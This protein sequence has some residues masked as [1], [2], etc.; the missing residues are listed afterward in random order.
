MKSKIGLTIAALAVAAGALADSAFLVLPANA[1]HI[2]LGF[3]LMR[4]LPPGRIEMACYSGTDEVE[5][6]EIFDRA[7]FRWLTVPQSYWN[8]GSIHGASQDVLIVVGESAA[9]EDLV[10]AAAWANNIFTPSDRNFH[11]TINAIH[12][13]S[14]LSRKQWKTLGKN[15]GITLREIKVPSRYERGRPSR[16]DAPATPAPQPEYATPAQTEGLELLPSEIIVT[17]KIPE[18]HDAE[19]PAPA[20]EPQAAVAPVAAPVAAP[21]TAPAPEAPAVEV[22]AEPAAPAEKPAAPAEPGIPATQVIETVTTAK[23][24]APEAPAAPAVQ[25]APEAHAGITFHITPP[26]TDKVVNPESVEAASTKAA[27]TKRTMKEAL[28][29]ARNELGASRDNA[30]EAIQL[31][32]P[33]VDFGTATEAPI[34]PETSALPPDEPPATF[35]KVPEIPV[36]PAISL[37]TTEKK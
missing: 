32:A 6:L 17:T 5:S 11:E 16:Y 37:E 27:A 23:P 9:A 34:I 18:S 1:N 4:M 7:S 30:G 14:P 2:N 19:A 25:A 28:D 22:T 33:E 26:A 13:V 31:P 20:A 8:D 21:V 3:D 24:A 36:V 29:K 10:A 15:Y 12:T 35:V